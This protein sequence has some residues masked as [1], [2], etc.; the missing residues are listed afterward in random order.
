MNKLF[1]VRF[2]IKILHFYRKCTQ[3]V[4]I[5]F[6]TRLTRSPPSTTAVPYV[7]S[8]DFTEALSFTRRL[9]K[10]QAV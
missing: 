7:N 10:I 3:N 4:Q 1:R 9:T 6:I 8:L 2:I 5:I